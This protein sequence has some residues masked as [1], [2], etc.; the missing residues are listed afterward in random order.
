MTRPT[1]FGWRPGPHDDLVWDLHQAATAAGWNSY[2]NLVVVL[3]T[4]R[5]GRGHRRVDLMLA[6]SNARVIV[7]AKTDLTWAYQRR[8]AAAQIGI[9]ADALEGRGAP[10]PHLLVVAHEVTAEQLGD[11]AIIPA[12][13]FVAALE[14]IAAEVL[15]SHGSAA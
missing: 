2:P 9:Y 3:S 1:Q 14:R 13:G 8:R 6:R 7:E 11:V 15:D 5:T 10:R 4:E 12:D